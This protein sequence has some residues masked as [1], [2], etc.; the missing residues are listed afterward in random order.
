MIFLGLGGDISY[1]TLIAVTEA[2]GRRYSKM[3]MHVT[4]ASSAWPACCVVMLA[5]EYAM[6][7]AERMLSYMRVFKKLL[8]CG[9]LCAC[10]I[11]L[12]SPAPSGHI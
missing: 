7:S 1:G 2:I 4:T 8:S 9:K 5:R 12:S 11:S 3:E 10:S 6:P